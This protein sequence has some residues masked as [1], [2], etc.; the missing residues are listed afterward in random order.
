MEDGSSAKARAK[1][2]L[3]EGKSKEFIMDETRLRLK[4]IKRIEREIT[5]KL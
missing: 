2:L 4:D 5:E 1:E 3:L